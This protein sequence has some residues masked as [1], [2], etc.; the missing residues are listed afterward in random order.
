MKGYITL[1]A[2]IIVGAIGVVIATSLLL[3]GTSYTKTSFAIEQ[4]G[5]AKLL[6][7]A[8]C[9]EALEQIRLSTGYTGTNTLNFGTGKSCTYIVTA[10]TG[11]NR[12]ITSASN[13]N[14]TIRK[15]KITLDKITPKINITYWQEV[16]DF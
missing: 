12:T 2:V 1:I 10:Q 13:V 4:S 3:L 15:V 11:E 8:C 7:N 16:A 5:E 6:A 9:E 14:N